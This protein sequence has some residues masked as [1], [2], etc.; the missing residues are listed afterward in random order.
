MKKK[1]HYSIAWP[2]AGR[3]LL[4]LISLLFLGILNTTAQ[5]SFTQT[6]DADFNK[7]YLDGVLV[8]SGSVS[9][10]VQA[11]NVNTWLTTTI[12]PQTLEGHRVST[13]KNQYVY[14]I[15]GHNNI[16]YNEQVYRATLQGS[17]ISG[18]T[19]L[20]P[21][22]VGLRDAAVVIGTNAIY[23][24]GGRNDTLISDQVYYATL[25]ADGS[26]GQW[27][28]SAVSMPVGLWGHTAT[29]HNGYIYISGGSHLASATSARANVYIARI[30]SDNT[31]FA[32]YNAANMPESKNGHTMVT[33]GENIFVLGGFSNG[34]TK[35][36]TVYYTT[37]NVNGSL[38]A[39]AA[40]TP[41][42]V[43][44]SN[45]SSVIVNGLITVMA[46]DPGGLLSNSV[47][48]A[49]VNSGLSFTWNL[50]PNIMYDRTKDGQGFASNGQII[51]CGGENLSGT[52][53]HN[54]RYAT[55]NLSADYSGKGVF[56]S[57]PFYELGAE[58]WMD[59]LTFSAASP[60][61]TTYE[62]TYRVAGNNMIWGDWSAPTSTSPVTINQTKRYLQYKVYFTSTGANTP[63]MQEMNLFT[64]GTELSGNLNSWSNFPVSLS[65]YWVTGDISLTSGSHTFEAGVTLNFLPETGFTIGQASVVCNGISGN[66]VTFKYFTDESG[67]WEGLYFDPN[68]DNG[69]SSQ[70]F[71]TDI[72]NAGFGS[73]NANL[74]CNSTNEPLLMNCNFNLAD[75]NGL[76]LNNSSITL[77]DCLFDGNTEN[78]VH[79]ENSNPSL[80]N[81]T[82]SAN[83]A[84]GVYLT[85]PV[86]EPNFANMALTNNLYGMH[87]PSPDFTIL[88]PNG[89]LS[90]TAN[91]Y[92]G[93]CLSE[94]NVANNQV[95]NSTAFDYV[96]LG[97]LTIGKYGDVS[98][99]TI[100]PGNTIK[101]L[102]GNNLRIGFH[103]AYHHAGELYAIG[104]V[105]ST[106]TFTSYDGSVGGWEEIY[107]E[108]RS[109]LWGATS[110]MDYCV[111]ENGNA[112]NVYIENTTVPAI[113]NC[114]FN[115]AVQ[116][117]IKC[118]GAYNSI[119][120]SSF[121][122][123][124]R[125]PLYFDEPLTSPTINGNT[126][127]GNT[128]NLIGYSGGA[129]NE[130]T[131]LQ[132]DGIGYH[133]LTNINVGRYGEVRRLTIEPGATLFFDP[134]TQIQV[135]Y[136]SGYYHG[137][138]LYAEGTAANPI[139][140]T[141]YDGIA[142]SWNGIYF[143][144]RSDW[145]GATNSMKHCVVEK[146][147]DYNI[148]VE[149]TS[150]VNIDSCIIQDAVSDGIRYYN[151]YGSFSNSTFSNNGRYPVYFTNWAA[152]PYHE[153][154]TFTS[155]G[156]N[157]IA[158]SGGS[159]T[160]SRSM[161]YDNGEYLVLNP[162]IVGVYGGVCRLTIDP[163]VI[164]NF[165]TAT[166]LQVGAWSG[167]YHGGEL[168][169]EANSDSMIVFKPYN[170]LSGGWDGIYFEDRSDW[171]GATSSMKYCTIENGDSYNVYCAVTNQ[172]TMENCILSDAAGI[173]FQLYNSSPIVRNITVSENGSYGIYLDGTSNPDI[174][175]DP[176][177]TCNLYLN[178]MYQ[179]YN[180]TTNHIDARY[181][182]WGT[183]DS[184]IIAQN[185]YDYYDNTAK[186]IV[187]FADFA[188]V[189]S[190]PQTTTELSGDV[191]YHNTPMTPMNNAAML[192]NDFG[193]API[194]N[195]TTNA[196]GHYGFTPFT[197]GNYTLDITPSDAF[198]GVNGTDALVVLNHFAHIDT[199]TGVELAAADVNA[200]ASVN[201]TDAL[202]ILKRW[203]GMITSFP[204]GDWLYNSA[205]LTVNGNQVIND[206]EMICFGDV[207]SS[208][209]PTDA[210]TGNVLLLAEGNQVI[211]SFTEFT[212]QVS[213]KEMIETGAISFGI[214]YPQEYMDITEATLS[215]AEGNAVITIND[216]LLR[217][218]WANLNA[219]AFQQDDIIFTISG[220]AKD[221]SGLTEPIQLEL[222]G[223]SEFT[224]VAAQPFS[225]VTLS[226]PQLV[227]MATGLNGQINT[228]LWLSDNYPNPFSK[229][230]TIR[231]HIPAEGHVILKVVNMFGETVTELVNNRQTQGE[232]TVELPAGDMRSGI[233]IYTLEFSN[234]NGKSRLINK[235]SVTR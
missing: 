208:Y 192:V 52:A 138:E 31:I 216:G 218:G 83:G 223:E 8:S 198:G 14:L 130:S 45:H 224:N 173:G 17:G 21:L 1:L 119:E 157:Y 22:P 49:D 219:L 112:Y 234:D 131:T 167:Y 35:R 136:H 78:G 47:Y 113:L 188:Q 13:W 106:I 50:S 180:N 171:N 55:L 147:N 72:V 179:V 62:I 67:G 15:G 135:G 199:L 44:I 5:V 172:P 43:S 69:V 87:Y 193:G 33:H 189:P 145:S 32:F 59:S 124:G 97:N 182:Y 215:G 29:Y 235:M 68:S 228:G 74:Y 141:P 12:L 76:R 79:L 154:N 63:N 81:S 160:E 70:F 3:L 178:G 109:D 57:N 196:L 142:G 165:D 56:V 155:K 144:D 132:E 166:Y 117:G 24:L 73:W 40:A 38:N 164:I 226:A 99:L 134:G 107:F 190:L 185:I 150:S 214:Y 127:T 233:Y 197:S 230:T 80:I 183:G 114:E 37:S 82:S 231:Y 125:Y 204:S 121:N 58:R 34:G 51:Y 103:S 2:L 98:R 65:P 86:S 203:A 30:I 104:T 28:V 100:E 48:Y 89:T 213:I 201:G 16:N 205:S 148:Y 128:I 11:T 110:V 122:N 126:W 25:N 139:T 4:G 10:P 133:I 162:I 210:A 225:A 156:I 212:I 66:P 61:G 161:Y 206:F 94:G 46:G 176:A 111:V 26:M 27:Q 19:T 101:F 200:S 153:N 175:N 222:M 75:G 18:W 7:G 202:F 207:N 60:V 71:Y 77:E 92:N 174:G 105:D 181:N 91:T 177:Y 195:T 159:F 221:L 118:Y 20:N 102:N 163:G 123:N 168:Y 194:A 186:G 116:D 170:G 158:L 220:M 120:T 64:P 39:W 184:A 209:M 85:S 149:N 227:T 96:M 88:P 152:S 23:V 187:I 93:I 90:M 232:Y 84:A 53:I 191:W 140:F 229:Q 143:E 95:W 129:V 6:T 137:G 42:P 54:T 146:A 151:G 9:L 211:S 41:L 169:A 108:D 217:I 115:D 36:N